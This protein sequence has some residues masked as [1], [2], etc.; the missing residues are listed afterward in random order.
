MYDAPNSD[1]AANLYS[2]TFCQRQHTYLGPTF[3][4]FK[5]KVRAFEN[6]R[7]D[8]TE[9]DASEFFPM[10]DSLSDV[11]PFCRV[12]DPMLYLVRYCF[13]IPAFTLIVHCLSLQSTLLSKIS[14]LA[15]ILLGK[16]MNCSYYGITRREW[17]LCNLE[18]ISDALIKLKY[19]YN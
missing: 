10:F 13:V 3:S 12:E 6:K 16:R 15:V 18:I 2:L 4:S 17:E 11:V 8:V 5:Q 7:I 14:K 19:K 1:T 9:L